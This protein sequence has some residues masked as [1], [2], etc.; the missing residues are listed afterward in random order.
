MLMS[1]QVTNAGPE[2]ETLH[3]LPTAWFRNTWSWEAKEPTN[4]S[5]PPAGPAAVGIEHPFLGGLELLAGP[6][7]GG[8]SPTLLFCDNE[9]NHGRL[10]GLSSSPAYPKDGINDHVVCTAR[11]PSTPSSGARS[12]QCGTGRR[13][14]RAPPSSCA[15]GCAGTG[16]SPKRGQ[17]PG[18]QLREGDRA[19]SGRRRTSSTPS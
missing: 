3:V 9:T 18:Q 1:I 13:W 15:C 8:G 17:R 5:W 12:A 10:Y 11:P 16:R 4:R 14:R 6:E 7:P 19:A 2:A